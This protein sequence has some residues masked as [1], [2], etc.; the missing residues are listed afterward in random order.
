MFRRYIIP[1]FAL[2]GFILA[3]RTVIVGNKTP[4]FAPPVVDP[5]V[6]PYASFVAGSGIVEPKSENISIASPIAGV[7]QKVHVQIGEKVKAGDPLFTLDERELTA[8][9]A[10]QRA[11]V[12]VANK[13]LSDV[14]DQYN[15]WNSV[16]DKRAVSE[17]EFIKKRNALV[18]GEERLRLSQAQLAATEVDLERHTIRAPID[19][20]VLQ[21]KVRVGEFAPAQAMSNPLMLLGATDTLHVRVDIDENDAWRVK[22]GEKG[23]AYLRGNT[24]LSV[25]LEF[26]RF[27][28]YV[29]PKRS[30]TGESTERVDTRV[31]QVIYSFKPG[32][33]PVFVGQ[34]MDVFIEAPERGKDK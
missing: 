30:L 14:R 19:G 29:I 1:L 28:P 20:E 12:E 11:N 3:I 27:E 8:R 6:V 15:L 2:L 7:V 26:V 22:P 9:K 31:L 23:R 5:P 10:V 33:I 13:E 24:E 17:E 25:P 21:V 32:T 4:P 16:K 18:T 34:L